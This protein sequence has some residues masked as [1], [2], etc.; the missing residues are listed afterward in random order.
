MATVDEVKDFLKAHLRDKLARA[1]TPDPGDDFSLV[2]SGIVDSFGLL[3]LLAA[4]EKRFGVQVEM[5]AHDL[6]VFTTFAGFATAVA[7]SS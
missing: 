6:D 4:A 5:G 3:D 2:E 7:A 1:G